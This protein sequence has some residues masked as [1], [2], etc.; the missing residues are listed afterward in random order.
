MRVLDIHP[1]P[2]CFDGSF[3]KEV[4]LDEAISEGFIRHLEKLG[5][6]QYFPFFA[7]P[8][9]RV[10]DFRRFSIQGIQGLT[11]LKVTFCRDVMDQ[12]IRELTEAIEGFED[13]Q[14]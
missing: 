8:F 9:F 11:S 3:I 6:L 12:S 1:M 13:C 2:N 5:D 7:R 10:D 4:L 14:L